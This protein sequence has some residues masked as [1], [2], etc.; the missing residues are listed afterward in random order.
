LKTIGVKDAAVLTGY[1]RNTIR[2]WLKAGLIPYRLAPLSNHPRIC[3][4]DLQAFFDSWEK[5]NCSNVSEPLKAENSVS[6]VSE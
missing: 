3:L 4:D 1:S 6:D 2:K 5:K